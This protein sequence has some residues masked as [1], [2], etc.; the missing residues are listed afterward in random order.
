LP[1]TTGR[2]PRA[3]CGRRAVFVL[4][5][6]S[7]GALAVPA[8]AVAQPVLGAGDDA[9]LPARGQL[10]V[11]ATLDLSSSSSRVGGPTGAGAG[12]V[13]L[14]AEFSTDALGPTQLPLLGP[15]RDTLRAIT[16][17]PALGLS[18]GEVRVNART[19]TA[20]APITAEYGITRRLALAVTVPF[21]QTRTSVGIEVNPN[22]GTGNFGLNPLQDA[23]TQ[24]AAVA[25]NLAALQN[26]DTA[27]TR[28]RGQG[29][30]AAA[31]ALEAA[32]FRAGLVSVYGRGT[33]SAGAFAVPLAG[34]D[35]Q[36]AVA[37]RLADLAARGV[38]LDPRVLPA[39][40][41]ARLGTAAFTALLLDPASGLA[42]GSGR[43]SPLG[44]YTR[45]G[46]GDVDLVAHVQLLDT[47]GGD[48]RDGGIR[49]RVAPRSGVRLRSTVG[50]GWRFGVG[51]GASPLILFDAPPAERASALLVR[52]AT[53]V[54]VGRRFSA[55]VVARLAA[56]VADRQTLRVPD[57]GQP[58]VPTYRLRTVD[59]QLGREVQL[60][61]TPR[62]AF[63]EAFALVA[64][65]VVRDRA[66]AR[67]S[68]TFTATPA[69]TGLGEVTFDAAA[70]GI[71]TGGREARAAIGFGYST[72]A[73][74]A[75]GRGRLPLELSYLHSVTAA[76]SRGAV[77]RVATDRVSVR[78][79]ARLFGR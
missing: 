60:E 37:A 11:R 76:A 22:G 72:L 19:S 55:S 1:L 79:Y 54:V 75:R 10:R 13:P 42:G 68:G 33:D 57:A 47:F 43:I 6:A 51:L 20:A 65:G 7:A 31:L 63:T 41:R 39:A 38:P 29:T 67:F 2:G 40:S 36:A 71:G 24:A 77:Q 53:D 52:S 32:R 46:L 16:G 78:V 66:A 3:L 58:Y 74:W 64:Q 49:A 25:Q 4:A 56:P 23:S 8:R 61:V 9:T 26:L 18:L 50:A 28:L 70:L 21:V 45:G 17:Q 15:V 48:G 69:E 62:Y 59:R 27:I 73:G 12:R 34:S 5:C 14:G 44:S 35:A 30:S